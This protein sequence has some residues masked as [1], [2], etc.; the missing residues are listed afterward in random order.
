M[1]ARNI[2][3][4]V[5]ARSL[6]LSTPQRELRVSFPRTISFHSTSGI[7][8]LVEGLPGSVLRPLGDNFTYAELFVKAIDGRCALLL[9]REMKF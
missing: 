1:Q 5:V 2:L 4:F 9:W 3:K 7:D 6:S 8:G